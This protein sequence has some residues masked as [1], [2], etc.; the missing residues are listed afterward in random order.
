[1]TQSGSRDNSAVFQTNAIVDGTNNLAMAITAINGV[2]P[3]LAG[4]VK[5]ATAI[6]SKPYTDAADKIGSILQVIP[7]IKE[8]LCDLK[9]KDSA[10]VLVSISGDLAEISKTL[11]NPN[12]FKIVTLA[13]DLKDFV[14]KINIGNDGIN[15]DTIKGV[16]NGVKSNLNGIYTIIDNPKKNDGILQLINNFEDLNISSDKTSEVFANVVA[17]ING[18]YGENGV[19]GTLLSL[20]DKY[21][22]NKVIGKDEKGEDIVELGVLERVKKVINSIKGNLNAIYTAINPTS[23]GAIGD[24][25]KKIV[26]N[27]DNSIDVDK[28]TGKDSM[29]YNIISAVNGIYGDQNTEGSLNWICGKFPEDS[30]LV[31][32]RTTITELKKSFTSSVPSIIEIAKTINNAAEKSITDESSAGLNGFSSG[33][34]KE[35]VTDKIIHI[36]QAT[37]NIIWEAFY[38]INDMVLTSKGG[39]TLSSIKDN[40]GDLKKNFPKTLEHVVAIANSLYKTQTNKIGGSEP[41]LSDFSINKGAP[42]ITLVTQIKDTIMTLYGK[43]LGLLT[44][45]GLK[46]DHL[47]NIKDAVGNVKKNFDNVSKSIVGIASI[48]YKLNLY[49]PYNET[50]PGLAGVTADKIKTNIS[51][52]SD[53]IKNMVDGIG[54]LYSSLY[55]DAVYLQVLMDGSTITVKSGS[56]EEQKEEQKGYVAIFTKAGKDI[57]KIKDAVISIYDGISRGGDELKNVSGADTT[58]FITGTTKAVNIFR[59]LNKQLTS[60][61]L[62]AAAVVDTRTTIDKM[63]KETPK[64]IK[65]FNNV[66]GEKGIMALFDNKNLNPKNWAKVKAQMPVMFA[67]IRNLMKSYVDFLNDLLSDKELQE[68]SKKDNKHILQLSDITNAL[69]CIFDN[70]DNTVQSFKNITKSVILGYPLIKLGVVVIRFAID[71]INNVTKYILNNLDT[72]S[73]EDAQKSSESMVVVVDSILKSMLKLLAIGALILLTPI[74]V[75]GVGAAM[76]VVWCVKQLVDIIIRCEEDFAKGE[77]LAALMQSTT[78]SLARILFFI[79]ALGLFAIITIPL[80]IV[81]MLAIVGIIYYVK[82]ICDMLS[83]FEDD[84]KDGKAAVKMVVGVVISFSLIA[85]ALIALSYLTTFFWTEILMGMGCTFAM[86]G[87]V[88]LISL[89]LDKMKKDIRG[90]ALACLLISATI[91]SLSLVVLALVLLGQIALRSYETALIGV[92]ATFALLVVIWGVFKLLDLIKAKDILM[93]IGLLALMVI[94]VALSAAMVAIL[95]II[96]TMVNPQLFFTLLTLVAI[97][98]VFAGLCAILGIPAV[99]AIVALGAAV[100]LLIAVTFIAMAAGLML[101]VKTLDMLADTINKLGNMSTKTLAKGVANA[102]VVIAGLITM[103]GAMIG[104]GAVCG[105]AILSIAPLFIITKTIASMVEIIQNLANLTVPIYE[106]GKKVGERSMDKSD[107]TDAL[108]NMKLITTSIIDMVGAIVDEGTL[109]KLKTT[110]ARKFK[111]LGAITSTISEMVSIVKNVADFRMNKYDDAGK[112]IGTRKLDV[113]TDLEPA[114]EMMKVVSSA[115]VSM[116]NNIISEGVLD[117]LSIK[118]KNRFERL[119]VVTGTLTDMV[120]IVKGMAETKVDTKTIEENLKSTI[121]GVISVINNETITNEVD[122]V[123]SNETK[124]DSTFRIINKVNETLEDF[125]KIENG[126]LKKNSDEVVKLIDKANSIDIS[127]ADKLTKLFE[128]LAE[129][130]ETIDGNFEHLADVINDKL[131]ES[132]TN[133]TDALEEPKSVDVKANV[134]TSGTQAR[135]QPLQSTEVKT[136]DLNPV[137][138]KLTE[139]QKAIQLLSTNGLEVRP[140]YGVVWP[141]KIQ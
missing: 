115:I 65:A 36:S 34:L 130:S 107:I 93:S 85:L 68:L 105:L 127:K 6:K 84:F 47:D 45:L 108:D 91:A 80:A 42:I 87:F 4:A 78:T 128:R 23:E 33:N 106:N 48:F 111:R 83:K 132:L 69:R 54:A 104:A 43:P 50:T 79:V 25:L 136:I 52:L 75:L 98:V 18:I 10:S 63:G 19:E 125:S 89:I 141:T 119:G 7:S 73:L 31:D 35:K 40:I 117:E 97:I 53:I 122:K 12:D 41:G 22:G 101:M 44:K 61:G 99:A 112:V 126:K 88:F 96:G 92:V 29:I 110:T 21:P 82:A 11:E 38:D 60:S 103:A 15:L 113:K 39:Y 26:N 109:D 77:Q 14:G 62:N 58:D 56:G 67:V 32:I 135:T 114:A 94:A 30:K 66:F 137:I 71:E 138:T 102:L 86:L 140:K 76:I 37:R 46:T 20:V 49:S 134:K 17:G 123:S 95:S 74:I 13:N 9:Y 64:L 24:S 124:Y 133:L 90:S 131:I 5:K 57:G 59:K 55:S 118:V 81:G 16:F 121:N 120:N 70:I 27:W 116:V 51:G 1:M 139:V 8:T 72:S 100:L 3:A 28:L 2:I 129:F